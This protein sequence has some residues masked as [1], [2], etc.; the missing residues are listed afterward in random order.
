M[1]PAI[2]T[3]LAVEPKKAALLNAQ[4]YANNSSSIALG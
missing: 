2:M 4:I 1:L 3:R